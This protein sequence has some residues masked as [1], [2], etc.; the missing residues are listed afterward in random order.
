MTVSATVGRNRLLKLAQLLE[1][2][3]INRFNYAEWVGS[4]WQG[5]SDLS[6]GT[7]GCALGWATT[8]PSLRRAG[9]RL[10]PFDDRKGGW[11]ALIY[12]GIR[13]ANSEGAAEK[14]FGISY[15]EAKYLFNGDMSAPYEMRSQL[16][17]SPNWDAKPAEVAK[18]IRRF[19]AV[20]FPSNK[21]RE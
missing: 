14:V 15:E 17:G 21:A 2:L 16:A 18:H 13:I 20:K 9:L 4:D 10:I 3:P 1:K 8:I 5:K 19:V 11:V 12:G 6:C 7:T